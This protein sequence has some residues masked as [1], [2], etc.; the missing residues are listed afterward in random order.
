MVILCLMGVL[1]VT[2][3]VTAEERSRVV[4]NLVDL[5]DISTFVRNNFNGLIQR[6]VPETSISKGAKKQPHKEAELKVEDHKHQ[7]TGEANSGDTSNVGGPLIL[8]PIE[9]FKSLIKKIDLQNIA[10]TMKRAMYVGIE[11]VLEPIVSIA[12]AIEGFV[13]TNGCTLK[14]VCGYGSNLIF[15]KDHIANIKP[16]LL[17]GSDFIGA[18][19]KGMSGARCEDAYICEPKSSDEVK[20]SKDVTMTSKLLDGVKKFRS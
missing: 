14:S 18:F 11:T 9:F 16:N 19:T 8:K 4:P 3:A 6:V 7:E 12:K 20:K 2:S 1:L 15:A 13:G 17:E 5:D 10:K